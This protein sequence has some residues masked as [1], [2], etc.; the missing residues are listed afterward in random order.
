MFDPA[1]LAGNGEVVWRTQLS[2]KLGTVNTTN[3]ILAVNYHSS[4]LR[5]HRRVK[6]MS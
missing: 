2:T 4:P 6:K 3:L 5:L 1:E